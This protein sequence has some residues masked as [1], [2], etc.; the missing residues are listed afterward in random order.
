M[1]F[2]VPMSLIVDKPGF[3]Q[4]V[5][6]HIKALTEFTKTRGK[7]RPVAHPLIEKAIKR[8]TYPI[9]DKKPD[10]FVADYV[11]KDDT[12][13]VQALSLEDKKNRLVAQLRNE[14]AIAKHKLL[15]QRK[16]RLFML[17]VG[18][19]SVKKDEDKIDADHALIAQHADLQAK[20][21]DLEHKAALA[22]SA[23]E[24]LTDDTVDSWQVPQ[25]G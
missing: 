3:E 19:A 13:Q 8:V 6:L 15:P 25:L 12:P 20:W 24:D 2:E 17:Q 21:N 11:F 10:G 5:A 7:P 9:K 1:P 4:G 22:E 23:I 14:E 18:A 16:V